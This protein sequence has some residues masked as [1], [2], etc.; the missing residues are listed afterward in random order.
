METKKIMEDSAINVAATL[1]SDP[2]LLAGTPE[3]IYIETKQPAE[4]T[5]VKVDHKQLPEQFCKTI[6][7]QRDLSTSTD[8]VSVR[9]GSLRRSDSKR[10]RCSEWSASLGVADNLLKGAAWNSIKIPGESLHEQSL[11]RV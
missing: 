7:S 1:C 2:S 3:S 10:F 5:A 6:Q 4:L 9:Q 8:E 11:V